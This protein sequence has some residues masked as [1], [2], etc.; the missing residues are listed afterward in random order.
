[1]SENKFMVATMR[2]FKQ[3][4]LGGI[5]IHNERKTKNHSND[6]IDVSKKKLNLDLVNEAGSYRKRISDRLM[7][8]RK[9][10]S[11]V[12]K[13]AVV[14]A[15]WI[16][17]ASPE[18]FEK[19]NENDVKK[20]FEWSL[21]YF[22]EKFGSKNVVYAKVHLDETTPHM[23]LGIVPLTSDGRLS[24]KDVFN[25]SVLRSV[26][27]E[28][29]VFLKS[30]GFDVKRGRK[31]ETR[32]KLTVPEYKKAQDDLAATRKENEYLEKRNK[33]LEVEF[34]REILHVTNTINSVLVTNAVI[35]PED[36]PL[37]F[38]DGIQKPIF[39][40]SIRNF[41]NTKTEL[42]AQA[43][44]P[45]R[46]ILKDVTIVSSEDNTPVNNV[47]AFKLS[48][49]NMLKDVREQL[50]KYIDRWKKSLRRYLNASVD[51]T[52]IGR[53]KV[54][55]EVAEWVDSERSDYAEGTFAEGNVLGESNRFLFV[56]PKISELKSR[57]SPTGDR[58]YTLTSPRKISRLRATF[59]KNSSVANPNDLLKN[60]DDTPE[61]AREIAKFYKPKVRKTSQRDIVRR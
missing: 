51:K 49:S 25:R 28:L 31:D 44:R 23:H 1:M 56:N 10:N 24:A 20:Y 38:Y 8:G 22:G 17:S 4:N 6:D 3:E 18:T 42:I 41:L 40:G 58:D 14:L 7:R 43:L 50:V 46:K 57:V 33:A 5:E 12:R 29:P 54:T 59:L 37:Y 45:P 36:E 26:Q 35:P 32:K 16:V 39:L 9:S 48:A 55:A 15:E 30:K 2:K 60:F 21:K 13:D 19:M 27:S 47:K 11:K 52:T 34:E 61:R 53:A